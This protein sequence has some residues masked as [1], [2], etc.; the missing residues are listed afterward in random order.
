MRTGCCTSTAQPSRFSWYYSHCFSLFAASAWRFPVRAKPV[1]DCSQQTPASASRFLLRLWFPFC[2]VLPPFAF[3]PW[4][5]VCFRPL[6][7]FKLA[8]LCNL[9]A[10]F[11]LKRHC[12]QSLEASVALASDAFIGSIRTGVFDYKLAENG[13]WDKWSLSESGNWNF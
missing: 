7:L 6:F 5:R 9:L 8:L 1:I 10:V 4:D 11:S 3:A 2:A 12:L 13:W